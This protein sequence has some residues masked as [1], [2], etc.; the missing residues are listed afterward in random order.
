MELYKEKSKCCGC[1]ACANICPKKAI[2]M[3]EDEEGFLYPQIDESKCVNC[4]LCK[5][6]CAFQE[7]YSISGR[8][9]DI[10]VY[11]AKSKN[12]ETKR[13]SSSG[14]MFTEISNY[15]LENNGVVYG[16]AFDKDFKVLHIRTTNESERNRCRGSKYSQSDLADVYSKVKLDLNNDK[17]VMFTGTPCQVAGLNKFLEGIN[18]EKLI[19]VDIVCHGTPSPKL[20]REYISFIENINKAK[21]KEYCHRSKDK[22]WRHIEK[23]VYDNGKEDSDT[24]LSQSWKQ[25]FYTNLALR[26][27]CY[28]CKYTNTLRPSDITI[29]DFWGIERTSPE[30]VD[31]QGVSLVIVNTKKGKEIFRNLKQNITSKDE[32]IENAIVKNPQLKRSVSIDI[33]KRKQFWNIYSK[34]GIKSIVRKYGKYNLVTFTKRKIKKILKIDK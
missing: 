25:I 34:K 3:V 31:K 4:G 1:T 27:T 5:K 10:E 32:K 21:V 6:V 16:A 13:E 11:A 22:G 20:F 18:K 15:V 33:K 2:T 17:L 28:N 19:L 8:L 23:V 29:A 30:F 26:K 9:E 14:G 12:Q 24:I 7:G